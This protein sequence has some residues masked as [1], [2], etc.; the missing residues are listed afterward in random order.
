MAMTTGTPQPLGSLSSRPDGW[1][2]SAWAGGAFETAFRPRTRFVT[3]EIVSDRHLVM[4]TLRGGAARH[5]FLNDDGQRHVGP[6]LA[7]SVSFLPAGC[8]RKLELHDVE[9]RWAAVALDPT[10]NSPGSVLASVGSIA[11]RDEPVVFGLLA[12][13]E[14][15]L[16]LSDDIEPIYAETITGAL[17]QYLA[18]KLGAWRMPESDYA[19]PPFKL[20]RAK[21]F[22][23][24]NLATRLSL[25]DLARLC[26][27]SERHFHRAFKAS[28]GR[29]PLEH[30]T[31]ERIDR[32]KL[33]L[34][35]SGDSIATV[36]LAVGFAN[37]SHFARTFAALT[38][39]T[40]SAYR[41]QASMR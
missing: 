16:A 17:A 33:M 9:W 2:R 24:A 41:A 39:V 35:S 20:R 36:A 13:M 29:T 34:A 30:I 31:A 27:L 38:G 40:P 11:L 3:G 1:R 26:D 23:A 25:A 32:A 6:D 5:A 37:P 7:G 21:E 22:I 14:R 10:T 15:L 19:L 12:E 8:V 18:R 4:A 28:I